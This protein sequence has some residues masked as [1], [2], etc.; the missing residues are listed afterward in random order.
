MKYEDMHLADLDKWNQVKTLWNQG[1]FDV[2]LAILQDASLTNK[3][4]NAAVFN[5]ITSTIL[6]LEGNEDDTFKQDII[7][8]SPTPPSGIKSGEVYFEV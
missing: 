8:V 7:K 6:N 3:V 4:V 2:A 5:N 1:N